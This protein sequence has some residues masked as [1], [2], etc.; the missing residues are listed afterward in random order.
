MG[1][2][3]DLDRLGLLEGFG[4]GFFNIKHFFN[5]VLH[6]FLFIKIS[7]SMSQRLVDRV[8]FPLLNLNLSISLQKLLKFYIQRPKITLS[9]NTAYRFIKSLLSILFSLFLYS[10]HLHL[11]YS[12]M[13]HLMISLLKPRLIRMKRPDLPMLD[14]QRIMKSS[15]RVINDPTFITCPSHHIR[16]HFGRPGHQLLESLSF[17]LFLLLF[18]NFSEFFRLLMGNCC[19]LFPDFLL[20]L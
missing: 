18:L 19:F 5:H 12:S 4:F 13:L 11:P 9:P 14:H 3:V 10:V 2:H 15:V 17:L 16:G 7:L 8:R 20:L 6:H 1:V